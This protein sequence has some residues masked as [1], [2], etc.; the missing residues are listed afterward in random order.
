VLSTTR[1]SAEIPLIAPSSKPYYEYSVGVG[2][3]FKLLRVDF[4]F[5]GNYLE[6]TNTRKFGITAGLRFNF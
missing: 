2:N 5:R 4:N 6:N 1:N 3:I